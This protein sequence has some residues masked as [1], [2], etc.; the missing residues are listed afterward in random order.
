MDESEEQIVNIEE[1]YRIK[2]KD[3]TPSLQAALIGGAVVFWLVLISLVMIFFHG[4]GW[5]VI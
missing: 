3:M 2:L 5:L 1:G 4:L